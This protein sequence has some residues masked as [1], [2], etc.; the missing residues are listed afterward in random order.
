MR[1]SGQ[2]RK[3]SLTNSLAFSPR[4]PKAFEGCWPGSWR[5]SSSYPKQKNESANAGLVVKDEVINELVE[6][7]MVG[8]VPESVAMMKGKSVLRGHHHPVLVVHL[9]GHLVQLLH[10]GLVDASR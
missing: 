5:G 6:A 7:G 1:R 2:G 9:D 8:G 3:G 4:A 10:E